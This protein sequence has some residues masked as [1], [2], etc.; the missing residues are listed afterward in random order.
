MIHPDTRLGVVDE[1]VGYGLFA[2]RPIPKGTITWVLDELDQLLPPSQVDRLGDPY[3]AALEHY[4]YP[5]SNGHRVLCWDIGRFMNHSCEPNSISP[6]VDFEIAVRDIAAGEQLLCDYGTLNLAG[7]FECRCGEPSC[8]GTVQ[9]EDFERFAPRWD[10]DV[11]AAFPR[12]RE[13][14]QP[15]WRLVSM[16]DR[17]AIE[18]GISAAE[19]IPSVLVHRFDGARERAR[20]R[21]RA[22]AR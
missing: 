12:I 16:R 7:A 2:T 22:V 15:L 6:G 10:Q 21:V 18:A 3:A 11:R 4:S 8:R 20:R 9:P 5:N 14:E 1:V 13:V 17:A 19:H